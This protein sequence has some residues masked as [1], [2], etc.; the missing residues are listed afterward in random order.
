MKLVETESQPV[1]LADY[2]DSLS[3]MNATVDEEAAEML[4]EKVPVMPRTRRLKM[5]AA[6]SLAALA[7]AGAVVFSVVRGHALAPV[8]VPT[9]KAGEG[10]SR[11]Y[12]ADGVYWRAPHRG[13]ATLSCHFAHMYECGSLCCC[14]EGHYW[15]S[16]KA[17]SVQAAGG[18][19]N[20]VDF[21]HDEQ[22]CTSKEYVPSDVI[23]A[24][25]DDADH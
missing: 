14:E 8:Q 25:Q 9:T 4:P 20:A 3:S 24:L 1:A 19:R 22:L 15:N 16:P 23:N 10:F 13:V 18:K 21:Y 11:F 17:A 6:A 12:D 7:L 5:L 2:L